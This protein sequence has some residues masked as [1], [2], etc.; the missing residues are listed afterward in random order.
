MSLCSRLTSEEIAAQ[1]RFAAQHA[2]NLTNEQR[3]LLTQAAK[4]LNLFFEDVNHNRKD[5]R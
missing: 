1:I 2:V 3:E 4:Y 5:S